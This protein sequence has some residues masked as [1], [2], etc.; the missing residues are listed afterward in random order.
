MARLKLV[1]DPNPILR[2]KNQDVILPIDEQ[3]RQLIDQMKFA[4]KKFK[5]IG[6]AA[7]Q[8]GKSLNLAI[9]NLEPYK[10]PP[11]PIINPR[12][13][14]TSSETEDM[15][16]GCLSIPHLF[17]LVKRPSK[18]KVE[19]YN[20][21]NKKITMSLD[22]LAARVFQH[23]IDH[24]NQILIKDKWDINTVH[25]IVANRL[26]AGKNSKPPKKK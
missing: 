13:I 4:C 2:Q 16:E 17:G 22:G 21:E 8:I 5:G 10:L 24:L 19:F 1:F 20:I 7:P 11:F 3:T 6:L 26:E 9:I 15:E 14:K 12:I 18:I 25:Q 23:E